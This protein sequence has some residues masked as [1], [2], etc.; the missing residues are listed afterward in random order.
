MFTNILRMLLTASISVTKRLQI[1]TSYPSME[2]ASV[3][4]GQILLSVGKHI[5]LLMFRFYFKFR[6]TA[7]VGNVTLVTIRDIRSFPHT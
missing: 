5:L 4:S 7:S 1:D 6:T 2:R 3:F